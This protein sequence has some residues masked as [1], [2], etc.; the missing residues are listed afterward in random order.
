MK[1]RKDL[2][3]DFINT[4][5]YE[6]D[7]KGVTTNFIADKLNMQ[8]TYVSSILNELVN[9][10]KIYKS[11]GRPVEY[12]LLTDAVSNKKESTF[13]SLIGSKYSLK[14]QIKIIESIL[15]Y[16]HEK[17]R[18]MIN[19][20]F[21][22][23]KKT[24]VEV[25]RTYLIE[26]EKKDVCEIAYVDC[27]KIEELVENEELSLSK[28]RFIIDGLKSY[29]QEITILCFENLDLL[30]KRIVNA[31]IN[32]FQKHLEIKYL[33]CLFNGNDNF[34]DL[35]D[36]VIDLPSY[37]EYTE[38]ERLEFIL[39]FLQTQSKLIKKKIRI[40][41]LSL[42]CL[43]YYNPEKNMEELKKD[44]FLACANLYNRTFDNKEDEVL[45]LFIKDFPDKIKR[46]LLLF[47][48]NANEG[49]FVLN[50]ELY[51][52]VDESKYIEKG[53]DKGE[54]TNELLSLNKILDS[55]LISMRNQGLTEKEIEIQVSNN[56]IFYFEQYMQNIAFSIRDDTQLIKIVGKKLANQVL[57]FLKKAGLELTRI[58]S[59]QLYYGLC[60]YINEVINEQKN[61]Y[62]HLNTLV[63]DISKNCEKEFK[64]A[65]DFCDEIGKFYSVKIPSQS[66]AIIT[67]I[68]VD[69]LAK[70]HKKQ[71]KVS[72]L[73]AM[74]GE[75]VA[76]SICKT[77][78]TLT[79]AAN[80][81]AFEVILDQSIQET[82]HKLR[83]V[84]LGLENEQG[85]LVFYDMGSI[86]E[87]FQLIAKELNVFVKLI[88]LPNTL[89]MMDTLKKS[90]IVNDLVSLYNLSLESYENSFSLLDRSYIRQEK[91]SCIITLCKKG[92]KEA[93]QIK[94]YLRENSNIAEYI[95]IV[96]IDSND[97]NYIYSQ[98]NRIRKDADV[99][100]VIGTVN[101]YVFDI[102]Y[103][104]LVKFLSI[105]IEQLEFSLFF[106]K[107]D[108]HNFRYGFSKV[109]QFIEEHMKNV[110]V[111]ALR[112]CIHQIYEVLKE[113]HLYISDE[114][115]LLILYKVASYIE[116][117]PLKQ[118]STQY[119][120]K[121][122]SQNKK[123]Y[124]SLKKLAIV[125][126]NN[127]N[128][129]IY[130]NELLEL[131]HIIKDK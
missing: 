14:E 124:Y 114:K 113:D 15:V 54:R 12:H 126:K 93:I 56:L 76:S 60:M 75:G 130:D 99:L 125:L 45:Y 101:P 110:D 85:I 4:Y 89:L 33:I 71:Q 13:H 105:P 67:L 81:S 53:N 22:V 102:P 11:Q 77:I 82:Y 123:L 55:V 10:R 47:N 74:H 26:H 16:P 79:H 34:Y 91:K 48:D 23:G 128:V 68:L 112:T 20:K 120:M 64:Q 103:L 127:F 38:E 44:I 42:K 43:L 73:V 131:I 95:D 52:I 46:G 59:N 37:S 21:G 61:Y 92:E 51:Y 27:A 94:N 58:Y 29:Y 24:F 62:M 98:L 90:E 84:V 28:A 116:V 121:L 1:T 106:S 80:M 40:D 87:M 104:S 6:E 86:K 35:F 18:I 9:E 7:N 96:P 100:C 83:E 88:P 63:E 5:L 31:F 72:I 70:K 69:I 17:I 57:E 111:N 109:C 118:E 117:E 30:S 129:N 3:L 78:T 49:K 41:S 107:T 119:N 8:R 65:K 32:Y 115:K 2:I 50:P 97:I 108:V 66:I 25:I 122:I 36:F 39:T 19:G